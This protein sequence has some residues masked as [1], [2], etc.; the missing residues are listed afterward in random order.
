[1]LADLAN[2]FGGELLL[3]ILSLISSEDKQHIQIVVGFQSS[4]FFN[5]S[6]LNVGVDR[7]IY[8]LLVVVPW[9]DVQVVA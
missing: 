8:A 6:S 2:M 3:A 7:E 4:F 5:T 9:H 1:M